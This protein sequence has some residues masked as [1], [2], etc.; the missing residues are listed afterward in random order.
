M[1]DGNGAVIQLGASPGPMVKRPLTRIA[2]ALGLP[3]LPY[4]NGERAPR[5]W[6]H[7]CY[8][9]PALDT[10]EPPPS[11]ALLSAE[12]AKER[13]REIVEG[14]FFRRLRSEDDK[15]IGR[16]LV[17]SPPGL[18]KTR[19]AMH[20]AIRYQAEQEGKDGTRLSLGDFNE[21]GVPAQTSIFVPRHQLAEELREVIQRAFRGRGEQ[22]SVPILRGRENGVRKGTRLAGRGERL[23]SRRAKGCRFT[24]ISANGSRTASRPSAPISPGASTSRPGRKPIARRS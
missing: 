19:E 15:R 2:Y 1:K 21:A 18:G 22:V 7:P 17:K 9:W 24:P 23:A 14:F 10:L 11:A 16:L 12:E 13:L 8:P 20:W 6:P 3:A 5:F 4:P